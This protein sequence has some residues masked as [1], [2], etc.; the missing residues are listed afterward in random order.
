MNITVPPNFNVPGPT[1]SYGT[2]TLNNGGSL[3]LYQ[4]TTVTIQ[5]VVKNA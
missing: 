5:Q 4:Q 1:V 2:V 3:L